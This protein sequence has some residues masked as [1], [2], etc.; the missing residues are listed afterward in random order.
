MVV[1]DTPSSNLPQT[2]DTGLPDAGYAGVLADIKA[3]VDAAR[4]R[5]LR[6][7]NAE[8]MG[9]YWH[10][11]RHIAEQEDA[12]PVKRG[13]TAPKIIARLSADLR[14][15]YPDTTGF[16]V[17]N[18]TYMRDF[19]RAWTEESI[20]QRGV[21]T[22]PWGSIIE[23]LGIR[24]PDIRAWYAERAGE[25]TRPVLQHHIANDLHLSQGAAPSNFERALPP[26]DAEAAQALTRDPLIVD[27]IRG[28]PGRE[29]DLELALLADIERFMTA[30]GKGFSFYGRQ[31][32]LTVGDR[33]FATDLLFYHHPQRRFVVIELKI[34]EFDPEHAGK[35]NFYVS[36]VDDQLAGEGDAPTIGILL[37]AT[38]DE[39]V[40]EMTLRGISSPIAVARWKTGSEM[41]MTEEPSV[42]PGMRAALQEMRDVEVE[43]TAFATRQIAAIEKSTAD[44]SRSS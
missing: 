12:A 22:L 2:V 34:G 37:C 40:T 8:L 25:W 36:T 29:R 18:L 4:V 41:T 31:L 1:E 19:S 10:I 42:S 43:L 21:A 15:A 30:L 23:L 3:R 26:G 7:A 5:A 32:A 44:P 9:V 14:A 39:A 35:L 38:R 6:A 16:S 20:L 33:E 17:R 27:F 24:D 11:G 28:A 13:H